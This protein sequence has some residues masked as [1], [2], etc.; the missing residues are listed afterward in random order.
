MSNNSTH[1]YDTISDNLVGVIGM[2][3][4]SAPRTDTIST[5]T[6]SAVCYDR[7]NRYLSNILFYIID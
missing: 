3:G 1:D 2:E 7:K 4:A 6:A 5:T